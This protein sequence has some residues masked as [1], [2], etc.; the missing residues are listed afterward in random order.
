V[1]A[2]LL[3]IVRRYFITGVHMGTFCEEKESYCSYL[4]LR[5]INVGK[6]FNVRFYLYLN[7]VIT[8]S[9]HEAMNRSN[10]LANCEK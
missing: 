8:C 6:L 10:S 4:F 2:A 3:M 7:N 9:F 5:M 1:F